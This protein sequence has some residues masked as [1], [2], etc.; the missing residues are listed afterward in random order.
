MSD[1][2]LVLGGGMAGVA[3]AWW[4][5]S[6][7]EPVHLVHG[8][9]GATALWNGVVDGLGGEISAEEREFLG[10]LG[11]V[12]ARPRPRLV[13]SLGTLREAHAHDSAMLDLEASRPKL[14]LVPAF[15]RPHWDAR[16]LAETLTANANGAFEA[17]IVSVPRLLLPEELALA[18]GAIARRLDDPARARAF[19]AEL[20]S[21]LERWRSTSTALL[22][23]P[24][25]GVA[26]PLRE[27]L[28]EALAIE[29][30]EVATT[31]AGAAGLRFAHRRGSLLD[32]L[33]VTVTR[34]RV[35]SVDARSEGVAFTLEDG[36]IV[37]GRAGVLAAGGFVSGALEV[38]RAVAE[39]EIAPSHR[40]RPSLA[41]EAPACRVGA[42][43]RAIVAEGSRYGFSTDEL[44]SSLR[45]PGLLER[46]GVLAEDDLALASQRELPVRVAGDLR[47]DGPRTVGAAIREGMRAAKAL[48]AR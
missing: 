36:S 25:L 35:V 41:F 24:W 1:P 6:R 12:H 18:D 20:E 39:K 21:A 30:G 14:V 19:V 37:R 8:A 32:R 28:R 46:L 9:A 5:A 17:R 22:V 3:A 26:Q 10:E 42:E 23:P 7:G 29:V 47:A 4:L 31:L 48:A 27:R 11:L 40:T 44:F 15:P 13:T 16:V 38:P 33:S 45:S 43:G 34:G 2:V